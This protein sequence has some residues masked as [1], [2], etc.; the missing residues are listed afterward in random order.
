MNREV[1]AYGG[2]NGLNEDI[3]PCDSN[4]HENSFDGYYDRYETLETNQDSPEKIHY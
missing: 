1:L 2:R 4:T 3:D